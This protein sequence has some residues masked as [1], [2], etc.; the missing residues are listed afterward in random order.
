MFP[1]DPK[2]EQLYRHNSGL[3]NGIKRKEYGMGLFPQFSP[4]RIQILGEMKV[5]NLSQEQAPTKGTYS[6]KKKKIKRILFS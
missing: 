3:K 1:H 6:K 5:N 2:C 4:S